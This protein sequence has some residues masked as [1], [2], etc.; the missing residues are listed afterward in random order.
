V[1]VKLGL[2]RCG[3]NRRIVRVNENWM[4][5]RVFA[6]GKEEGAGENV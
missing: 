4:V 2:S 1:G 3:K 5:R 6:M